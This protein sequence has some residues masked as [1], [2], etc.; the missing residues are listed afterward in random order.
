MP[1]IF[2][3]RKK[4]LNEFNANCCLYILCTHN[5]E[6]NLSRHATFIT[7]ISSTLFKNIHCQQYYL[8]SSVCS[9]LG[10]M[11]VVT[12]NMMKRADKSRSSD[13]KE[14]LSN[15]KPLQ[16]KKNNIICES[17]YALA[18]QPPAH[19]TQTASSHFQQY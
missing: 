9:L 7:H 1:S 18:I 15:V 10:V 14:L 8:N 4:N 11:V 5:R 13:T 3:I 16:E 17:H 2:H 19:N 6:K 12:E